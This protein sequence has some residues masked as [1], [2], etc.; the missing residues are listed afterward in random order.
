M[1]D[2]DRNNVLQ[3][4]T[5]NR[6][7]DRFTL[8]EVIQMTEHLVHSR[9]PGQRAMLEASADSARAL[10]APVTVK[11]EPVDY[12]FMEEIKMQMAYMRDSYDSN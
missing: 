1:L 9:N 11:T 4:P 3:A 6:P 12:Q 5:H 10:E 7:E 8:D 2:L